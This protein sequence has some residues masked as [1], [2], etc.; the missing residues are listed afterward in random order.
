M[1]PVLLFRGIVPADDPLLHNMTV[2]AIR[3]VIRGSNLDVLQDV[4]RRVSV[5]MP[6]PRGQRAAD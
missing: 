4:A 6:P 1:L 3:V 2:A 5:G